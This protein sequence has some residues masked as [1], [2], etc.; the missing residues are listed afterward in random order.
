MQCVYLYWTTRSH[1]SQARYKYTRGV[2]QDQN[3]RDYHKLWERTVDQWDKLVLDQCIIDKTVGGW[4]KRLRACALCA[5]LQKKDSFNMT[6]R[7]LFSLLTVVCY[8]WRVLQVKDGLF[9]GWL[10]LASCAV[11]CIKLTNRITFR[12][13]LHVTIGNHA[14]QCSAVLSYSRRDG[15]TYEQ[16]WCLKFG[17]V[18]TK[19]IQ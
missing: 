4:R 6:C 13:R 14:V 1:S 12:P 17:K 11:Q 10:K 8:F 5:W 19:C 7:L 2:V 16:C 18:W 15:E 3:Q 9:T